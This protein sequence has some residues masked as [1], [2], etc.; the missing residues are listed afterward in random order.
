MSLIEMEGGGGEGGS[1]LTG[2]E[3][4]ALE[5]GKGRHILVLV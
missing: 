2:P 1:V 4:P 5:T 3:N